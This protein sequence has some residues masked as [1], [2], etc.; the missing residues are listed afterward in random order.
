[1]R[2]QRRILLARTD[3]LGDVVL[4]TPAIRELRRVFPDAFIAVMV[5]PYAG[6]IVKNDPH[7][8]EVILYDKNGAHSGFFQTLRFAFS[9][10]K[11]R[12]DSA[13]SF[14]P[15]NRTHLI[16]FFSGIPE[17][18]GYDRNMPYL[19][20]KKVPHDKQ[21]GDMHEAEY[22][23]DL[24]EKL[25]IPV[26]K[27]DLCPI[28]VTSRSEKE[29]VDKIITEK[30]I[31]KR[32]VVFHAGASCLSKIWSYENF[33]E[34]A[35]RTRDEFGLD[36][37]LIGSLETLSIN[38]K[39]VSIVKKSVHDL[40]GVLSVGET[41]ELIRRSV[42]L[43]SNDSGPVHIASAVGTPNVVIFGRK[44]PGLSPLRWGPL[45]KTDR[46]L[47]KDAGCIACLAHNC[48]KGFRC[49]NSVTV[50]EVFDSAVHI[51]SKHD[52]VS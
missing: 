6:D 26:S 10:R 42:L 39:I 30:G 38:E 34:V 12:F 4:T 7:I 46:V 48:V 22:N 31:K 25:G 16:F 2:K 9:L 43:I 23:L 45:G 19:L 35:V 17:R 11:Y 47:H 3:R 32:F 28:M 18:A 24:L 37:V 50:Q 15:N 29:L 13:I 14:H 21:K 40:A 20:T 27:D 52:T 49:I 51:I 33:A 1:M 8:D 41:A 36:I 5:R 44:D